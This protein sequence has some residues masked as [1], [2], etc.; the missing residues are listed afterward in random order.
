MTGV[1]GYRV[2]PP[3]LSGEVNALAVRSHTHDGV[4]PL[5]EQTIL[6]LRRLPAS[7]SDA[8]PIDL[9][10]SAAP[11]SDTELLP[12]LVILDRPGEIDA[13]VLAYA[14][15][16]GTDPVS[17]EI[18]VDP[19]ERGGGH[20]PTLAKQILQRWPD[21]R[22]WAHGHLPA[23]QAI[24]RRFGLTAVRELWQMSRPLQGEWAQLPDLELPEGFEV[25]R[26][27]VGQDDARWLRVNARAFANH[28]EQGRMTRVD[29]GER[30]S[31]PWFDPHGFLLVEDLSTS[32]STD[33][34]D[35]AESAGDAPQPRLAAFHWTKVEPAEPGGSEPAAGE[36][37]VVGVD[38]DYQGK[39]LGVVTTLLGLR[40]LR[41]RGLD[42]VTLY[43]DGDNAAA[44]ATYHRL[45]FERSAVDV[46][47][48]QET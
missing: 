13:S 48:A 2:L 1:V 22:F 24:A 6:E 7:P 12:H 21:A 35:I 43:V 10:E 15:I 32:D 41:A 3:R 25:R 38:P 33:D 19:A 17:V 29:L 30:I 47:F 18:I 16:E 28:P 37:Y 14:H 26:F 20:G 39:G 31:E 4:K 44:I 40:H 45:G 23:T 9:G 36:V 42:R 8:D 11:G 5:S 27:R 34:A 46:M